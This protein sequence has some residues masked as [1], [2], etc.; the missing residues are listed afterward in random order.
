MNKKLREKLEEITSQNIGNNISKQITLIKELEFPHSIKLKQEAVLGQ[1]STF[2]FNCFMHVLD[3]IGLSQVENIM[4]EHSDVFVGSDFMDYLINNKLQK[5]DS[6][7]KKD[8]DI[9]IYFFNSK[10]E[11]AGKIYSNRIISKW[12][13]GHLWEHDIFEIPQSYGNEFGVFKSILR[14]E[15]LTHFLDYARSK[16]VK[17]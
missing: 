2:Q 12:G 5:I 16:G 15:T 4:K 17:C 8:G 3:L 11:H 1:P 13:T 14:Q 7:R 9:A 6:D 10:P